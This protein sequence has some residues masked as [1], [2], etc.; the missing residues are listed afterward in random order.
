MEFYSIYYALVF[1][2]KQFK[3]TLKY[4]FFFHFQATGEF[5]I[6]PLPASNPHSKLFT[7]EPMKCTV[8]AGT[9]K[10]VTITFCPPENDKSPNDYE[11]DTKVSEEI[12]IAYI[13]EIL[14]PA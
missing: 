6:D 11:V 13:D 10:T 2:D 9:F 7:I 14:T 1:T 8:E 4:N 12:N 3:S 5:V